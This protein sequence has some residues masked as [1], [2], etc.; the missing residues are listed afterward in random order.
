M[1]RS[2]ATTVSQLKINDFSGET[3]KGFEVLYFSMSAKTTQLLSSGEFC[4]LRCDT[5]PVLK[6]HL[7]T[8]LSIPITQKCQILSCDT[9]VANER[10]AAHRRSIYTDF[11]LFR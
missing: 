9:L 8:F 11:S 4:I 2:F 10:Y 3:F 6:V 5:I 1:N 7:Q